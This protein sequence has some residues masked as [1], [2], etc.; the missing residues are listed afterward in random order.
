MDVIEAL[1]Q[2]H[3]KVL[4]HDPYVPK[5]N[6]GAHQLTSVDL[7]E[8]TVKDANLVIILTDHSNLDYSMI[9]NQAKAVLDT[10]GITRKLDSKKVVL[11]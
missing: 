11:L 10:R 3:A 4:Y 6:L 1:L 2:D 5:I 7:T 9:L 8:T